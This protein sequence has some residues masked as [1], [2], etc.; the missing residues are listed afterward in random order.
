MASVRLHLRST[1]LGA[2][3]LDERNSSKIENPHHVKTEFR[4]FKHVLNVQKLSA[5]HTS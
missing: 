3:T 5:S 2:R 1:M 4:L